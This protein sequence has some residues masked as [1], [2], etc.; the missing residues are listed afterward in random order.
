MTETIL[1][2][3][4]FI[5]IIVLA[6][7]EIVN[8]RQIGKLKEV[9]NEMYL[10]VATDRSEIYKELDAI[11]DSYD[12]TQIELQLVAGRCNAC[13]NKCDCTDGDCTKKKTEIPT[14]AKPKRSR[15]PKK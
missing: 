12:V 4:G 7:V 15:T 10:T 6:V 9:L 11:R 13:E 3:L 2:I 8:Y 1:A 5:L 14:E